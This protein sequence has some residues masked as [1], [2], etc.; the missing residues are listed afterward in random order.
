MTN[1]EKKSNEKWS[2]KKTILLI[3]LVVLLFASLFSCGLNVFKTTYNKVNQVNY[4][5]TTE[6]LT[7][8]TSFN[9][10]DRGMN[11]LITSKNQVVSSESVY[12]EN[13]SMVNT[14]LDYTPFFEQLTYVEFNGQLVYVIFMSTNTDKTLCV[15][16]EYD[17]Y[18]ND[19]RYE[20]LML[21][22]ATMGLL[23]VYLSSAFNADKSV[24]YL[25][26]PNAID[27][28]IESYG[29]SNFQ[30]IPI[31]AQNDLLTG[32]LSMNGGFRYEQDSS[33]GSYTP[34]PQY[35]IVQPSINGDL[36]LG[37]LFEPIFESQTS[38][39]EL[40][41]SYII[42]QSN[43]NYSLNMVINLVLEG[44]NNYVN[45]PISNTLNIN[46]LTNNSYTDI[47]INFDSDLEEVTLN[48]VVYSNN[49]SIYTYNNSFS[50]VMNNSVVY[51]FQV[52]GFS[53][54]QI[55]KQYVSSYNSTQGY[56]NGLNIG[57]QEGYSNGYQVGYDVGF[58][59]G[60]NYTDSNGNYRGY[61]QGYHDG[62]NNEFAKDGVKDLVNI[63][64]NAPYN[65]FNG[66]L[67]FEI[68]GVNLFNLLSFVFTLVLVGWIIALLM[69]R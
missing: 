30:G 40:Y 48:I 26:N 1:N 45:V 52:S 19:Y 5:V 23:D 12:V 13:I 27:I 14:W 57:R 64:F 60:Y 43:S 20:V 61:E 44:T 55:A 6:I 51:P 50:S 46:D 34:N 33:G 24:A 32:V 65:I 4:D 29:I 31:G 59:E 54:T 69:K 25:C 35:N 21:N 53:N 9:K 49:T 16:K 68:F 42:G 3:V 39:A 58:N 67:N 22:F 66:F 15:F 10:I 11:K 17:S 36:V 56:N 62:S 38:F 2:L 63:I 37:T 47:I 8:Y 18:A 7:D 28:Q 41:V